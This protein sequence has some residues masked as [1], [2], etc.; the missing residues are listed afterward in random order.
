MNSLFA[1]FKS[2]SKVVYTYITESK[3]LKISTDLDYNVLTTWVSGRSNKYRIHRI[4]VNTSVNGYITINGR[5]VLVKPLITDVSTIQVIGCTCP[6]IDVTAIA[7]A[8][9]LKKDIKLTNDDIL[10]STGDLTY[11]DWL[12]GLEVKPTS[13]FPNLVN[14]FCNQIT[15]PAWKPIFWSQ[16]DFVPYLIA[17]LDDHDYWKDNSKKEYNPNKADMLAFYRYIFAVDLHENTP[18]SMARVVDLG[19][20]K[21]YCQDDIFLDNTYVRPSSDTLSIYLT[22]RIPYSYKIKDSSATIKEDVSSFGVDKSRLLTLSGNPH[23]S[24]AYKTPE[25]FT[26]VVSSGLMNSNAGEADY[27]R[28]LIFDS[29]RD[30]KNKRSWV[31]VDIANNTFTVALK[32]T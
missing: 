30:I 26:I 28:N 25:D 20:L 9:A 17:I 6:F 14:R 10:I 32:S 1:A 2:S 18:N 31:R 13:L 29:Q 24:F 7:Q 8:K 22:P 19:N 11:L 5:Q 15:H 12:P 3:D 27:Q 23:R 21:V 4:E 16:D